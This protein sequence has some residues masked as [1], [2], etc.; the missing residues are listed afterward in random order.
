[1]FEYLTLN[2][3]AF[4]L[5]ISDRSIKAVELKKKRGNLELSFFRKTRLPSGV[6]VSGEIKDEKVLIE[7]IKS[8]LWTCGKKLR[9]RKVVVALP[10]E[11]AFLQIIQMPRMSA[12]EL[13]RAVV[14]EAEDYIPM[15]RDEIYL[16]FKVIEPIAADHLDVMIAALPK[17][18]ADPYF[19]VVREAGLELVVSEIEPHAIAR[20]VIGKNY[21]SGQVLIVDLG[22]TRTRFIIFADNAIRFFSSSPICGRVFDQAIADGL[23]IGIEEAEKLKIDYGTEGKIGIDPDGDEKRINLRKI[24]EPILSR[25]VVQIGNFI[26]Y[27]S[28]HATD[29]HLSSSDGPIDKIILCGGNA[30]TDGIRERLEERLDCTVEVVNPIN[31]IKMRGASMPPGYTTALGLAIRGT[32]RKFY[33]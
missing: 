5:D 12:E 16:D 27:Y 7:A 2:N 23:E 13:K 32:N 33:D 30:R 14:F 6:M 8:C 9:S 19:R 26:D 21:T 31:N 20:A 10:E 15:S 17:K 3:D 11:R 28:S 29:R 18:V 24:M 4:G 25:L 22:E 1:M